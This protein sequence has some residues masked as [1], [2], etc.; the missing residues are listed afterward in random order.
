MILR[1]KSESSIFHQAMRIYD[2]LVQNGWIK[3]SAGDVLNK[4]SSAGSDSVHVKH[5]EVRFCYPVSL[6]GK[7]F[8]FLLSIIHS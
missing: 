6:S 2:L 5:E 3:E 7:P 8:L 1:T 4:D